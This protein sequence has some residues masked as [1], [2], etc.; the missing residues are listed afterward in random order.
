M[1]QCP[2]NKNYIIPDLMKFRCFTCENEFILSEKNDNSSVFCPYCGDKNCEG[3][4]ELNN[5][6]VLGELGDVA[7]SL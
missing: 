2:H 6:D 1:Y 5:P 3:V 7:I 4:A